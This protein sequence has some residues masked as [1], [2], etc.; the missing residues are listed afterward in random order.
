M[1]P[2]AGNAWT[3]AVGKQTSQGT[4]QATPAYKLRYTGGFGPRP[5]R[6]LIDLAESDANRQVG[7]QAVVG[8]RVEG[9]SEHYVRPDEF[10]LLAYLLLGA[11]TVTGAGADK[12]HTISSTSSGSAPFATLFRA[13]NVTTMVDRYVDCQVGALTARG[14]AEQALNCTASWLGLS[15]LLGQTDAGSAPITQAPLVYPE[16]TVTMGGSTTAIVESFEIT[17]TQNRSL[18]IGD[19]G[20]SASAVAAGQFAVTGSMSVLF[21][22]DA[23]YRA[24][25]TGTTVGTTPGTT[26]FTESLNILAQRTA[27]LSVA[28][29]MDAISYTAYD[30]PGNTDG[31]PI[32]VGMDFRSQRGAALANALEVIVKNQV[33]A[34]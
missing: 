10:G 8:L 5:G 34:Y 29:D 31:A 30:P 2:V 13:L 12:T 18:I 17:M 7:D 19:T 6:Q 3:L 20:L 28:F 14:G 32:R 9:D 22:S 1:A 23:Y 26:I 4:P 15:A 24:F 16:V 25:H 33:V 21:E 27:V 11:D